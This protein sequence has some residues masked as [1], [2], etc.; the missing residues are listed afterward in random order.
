MLQPKANK[1]PWLINHGKRTSI[2]NSYNTTEVLKRYSDFIF[3]LL[4]LII[5]HLALSK[6]YIIII[7]SINNVNNRS[8]A[9]F[10]KSYSILSS[11]I[12]CPSQAKPL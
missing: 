9:A 2:K 5:K 11:L 6:F 7:P 3:V 1:K 4:F 8:F 10:Q 12:R